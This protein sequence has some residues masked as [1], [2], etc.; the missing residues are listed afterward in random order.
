MTLYGNIQKYKM[1]YNPNK[2]EE[3]KFKDSYKTP[4]LLYQWPAYGNQI[5]KLDR[6]SIKWLT[7]KYCYATIAANQSIPNNTSTVINFDTFT[8]NDSR[9]SATDWRITI[10]ATWLYVVEACSVY[11]AGWSWVVFHDIL[12]NW[13]A[14][15]WDST[16]WF[17]K[18]EHKVYS[19]PNVC[20]LTTTLLL[21]QNDY[22]QLSVFQDSWW[23]VNWYAD[24]YTQLRIISYVLY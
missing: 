12:R 22:I 1:T 4:E 2:P 17:Y 7:P 16:Q 14:Q 10:P 13:S 20:N 21:N 5:E 19:P 11:T 18:Q 6:Q 8:T 23:A 24:P 9:M 15:L 3:P